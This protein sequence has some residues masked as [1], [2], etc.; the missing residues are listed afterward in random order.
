M[1]WCAD[2][3]YISEGQGNHSSTE[4]SACSKLS[5]NGFKCLQFIEYGG[6]Q[7]S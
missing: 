5:T 6:S 7:F 2:G 1:F 4:L 3:N